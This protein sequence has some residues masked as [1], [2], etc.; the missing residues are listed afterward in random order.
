M[1]KYQRVASVLRGESPD[2]VPVG[3]WHHNPTDLSAAQ[4]ADVQYQLYK[5]ADLD[6]IKIMYDLGYHLD[7]RITD[8]KS[9]R[10]ILPLGCKSPYYLKQ[11]EIVRRV[12]DRTQG[13]CM[14]W[15]TMFSPMK[16]A[17]IAES[18]ELVM[19]HCRENPED[20]KVGLDALC[21][22]LLE[23]GHGF[24][25][26]GAHGIYYSAQFGEIGR[27][28]KAEWENLVKPYDLQILEISKEY[29]DKYSILHLCGEPEY[30]YKVHIDWFKNYP[31]DM[32]NWA[33]YDNN[34]SLREGKELFARPILGGM[35]NRGVLARGSIEEV[36]AQAHAAIVEHGMQGF[37]LGA[38]CSVLSAD[39]LD[40]VKAAV[41]VAREFGS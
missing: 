28:N 12:L 34:F 17:T 23:W 14:V 39:S 11:A 5:D 31:G 7:Q 37:M 40:R 10:H 1:N 4:H 24:L 3:F 13:E 35:D 25:E 15:V 9:W 6:V 19:A 26:L 32:C 41:T 16:F 27:F 30:K 33:I 38:D 21:E 2:V 8:V 36:R 29:I 18:D 20:F 22:A